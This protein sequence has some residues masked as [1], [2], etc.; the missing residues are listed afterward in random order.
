M[1]R[2][3]RS[4]LLGLATLSVGA[5]TASAGQFKKAV[6]Y[7]AG[8]RP[9][10]VATAL[11]T[12]SGNLDLA[13]ADWV[14]NRVVI[15]LGNGDGTFQPPRTFAV[16]SPIGIATGDFNED[17]NEDLA[18]VE[19]NGTGDGSV[20][21]FLG[22]GKGGF[23][24]SASY[25]IGVLSN[26]ATVADFNGDGHLD[27]AVTNR[28]FNKPGNLMVFFGDGHGKLANRT[29]Y[30]ISGA[31]LGISAGDLNGDHHPDLAIADVTGGNVF[32]LL[33]DGTG[34][35]KKPVS[36]SAGGGEVVDVKIADL[37]NDGKQDLVMANLSQGMVV[38]LNQGNGTFGKPAIYR[39]CSNNCVAPVAAVVADFNLDGHLDVAVAAQEND[40]YLFYGKGDGTFGLAVPISDPIKSNGGFS[41]AAGDFNNDNAPDLAIPVE[42]Y[43]KVA[44]LLNTQ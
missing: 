29:T 12:Q 24:L 40:S 35:F 2:T 32:V 14:I 19:S 18:V 42:Q 9:Y 41:I 16:P 25:L 13:F 23:K 8:Q 22:D 7:R 38:L 39:P 21:I 17:G 33:N 1:I 15:L 20:A 4:L 10:K 44:I 3:L 31:P 27:V 28:G 6:Y 11:F 26:S 43:G 30:K 34:H 5:S 36:Y 37:R